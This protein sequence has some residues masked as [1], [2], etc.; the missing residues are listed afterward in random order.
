MAMMQKYRIH[1]VAKDFKTTSKVIGEIMTKYFEAPK[2][3]MQILEDRELNVIF[4]RLTQDHQVQSVEELPQ[5]PDM[6]TSEGV[7]KLRDAISALQETDDAQVTI[8]DEQ[9][10]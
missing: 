3:H 1:E 8:F 10:G 5:L 6:T 9:E 2:N 4:E 7:Q